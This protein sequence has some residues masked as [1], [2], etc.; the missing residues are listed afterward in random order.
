MRQFNLEHRGDPWDGNFWHCSKSCLAMLRLFRLAFVATQRAIRYRR[1]SG[2]SRSHT[3]NIALEPVSASCW[4]EGLV[5]HTTILTSEFLLTGLQSTVLLIHFRCGANQYLF[6]LYQSVAQNLSDMWRSTKSNVTRK[7]NNFS[8][9]GDSG[10][11]LRVYCV[12]WS[13]LLF[14][15]CGV[16]FSRTR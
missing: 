13:L 7:E 3:S 10:S 15:G 16:T 4:R 12:D 6:I 11:R 14:S 2:T 8:V 1:S 9:Q 5:N